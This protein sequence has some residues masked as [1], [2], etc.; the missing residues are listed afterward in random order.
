MTVRGARQNVEAS[1]ESGREAP[2]P[3]LSAEELFR[4]MVLH[5]VSRNKTFGS[6]ASEGYR[7]VHRRYRI[8]RALQREAERLAGIS[9]SW[10]HV[11]TKEG[12]LQV[13]LE[14][15]T[16]YYRREVGLLP[17]E[18]EWLGAQTGIR[19]LLAAAVAAR[20]DRAEMLVL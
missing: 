3:E 16:L 19:T 1:A 18:W 10:C 8:V 12:V 7:R 5:E 20:V 9:G 11:L 6:F 2:V 13:C 14:S 17:Y 4:A 15:P